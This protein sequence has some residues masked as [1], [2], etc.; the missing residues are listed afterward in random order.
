M[1]VF[2][3]GMYRAC[4]TWQYEVIAH[5]LERHRRGQRL[6]YLT[7]EEFVRRERACEGQSQTGWSVLKSHEGHRRFAEAIE[8]G[9]A[10]AIYARRDLR[11]VVFS[12]MHK[13]GVS[14]E[15]LVR[16]GMIH[17][18]LV[19]DRFWSTRPNVLIQRY[20]RL[21]ADPARGVQE[22]AAHLGI[23]ITAEEA[24]EIAAEYSF[25]TNRHRTLE[26]VERLRS[27]GIDLEHPSNRQ[28]YDPRTLLH[29]NHMREGRPGNWREEATSGQRAILARLCNRWLA[30]HG[31][32]TETADSLGERAKAGQRFG[33]QWELARAWLA[34]ALRCIS[35][36][37][38]QSAR[39]VKR[40]LGIPNNAAVAMAAAGR[41]RL[42]ID[43]AH[44]RRVRPTARLIVRERTL[45]ARRASE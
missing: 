6:G 2:A 23:D 17:Q 16:Q 18:V 42:R 15:A 10:V 32:E 45:Q 1:Y 38:P 7:G 3:A 13:R 28:Y 19:N 43:L 9:R 27:Q 39:S 8:E 22:I 25:Q 4:S 35:L 29:W 33:K 14:F 41:T 30:E 24:A 11:D 37:Y 44:G 21:I 5:L 36:E 40:L 31:Y 12:L 20:E 26:L 34:C